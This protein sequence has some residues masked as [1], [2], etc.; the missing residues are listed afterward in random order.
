M[1]IMKLPTAAAALALS[2]LTVTNAAA[3]GVF[4]P[5]RISYDSL[6]HPQGPQDDDTRFLKAL[7][8]V[9]MIS[10]TNIPSFHK[11]E[12]LQS[13]TACAKE[14]K[15]AMEHVFFDGTRRRTLATHSFAGDLQTMQHESNACHD[16]DKHS[17][18]FRQMV[19]DV[20]HGFAV[21]LAAALDIDEP[22]LFSANKDYSL[23]QVVDQGEHLE[24]FHTYQTEAGASEQETI[25]WHIDQGLA[26]IFTPGLIHG[27][28]AQGFYIELADG[29]VMVDFEEQDDLVILLGDGVNQYVNAA[30]QVPLRALP[31]SLQ[32]PNDD[33][34]RVWYG[35]M[36]LPPSD[37]IHPV[38]L[39]TFGDL[40]ES[41]IH[42]N[43]LAVGCSSTMYARQ[44]E[45]T[46]CEQDSFF[47]WHRCFNLTEELSPEACA[48]EG[49][50]LACINDERE[51]WIGDHNPNFYPGCVDLD[52]A[53]NYTKPENS[54]VDNGEHD[55][56][57]H[58]GTTVNDSSAVAISRVTAGAL[59]VAFASLFI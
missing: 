38:H 21:R 4:T 2:W 40:R 28:P 45:E 27:E 51:L 31:H 19:A 42:K 10:I 8:D 37:A 43:D 36:V 18:V 46:S 39:Q 11:K 47:C 34:P 12:T 29:V 24:H 50:D 14:S 53:V 30:L 15:A 58:E 35:R 54:T 23:V 56:D 22:L 52:T 20:T 55:G 48:V 7:Q 32:M 17:R 13:I 16:L 6:T 25:E 41:M 44:L 9:G 59:V 33:E 5:T 3:S 26:L 49:L 1:A 57:T